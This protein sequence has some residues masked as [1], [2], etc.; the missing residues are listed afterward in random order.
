[1][2]TWI[3][4]IAML[5]SDCDPELWRT[6][7]RICCQKELKTESKLRTLTWGM[8]P[9]NGDP[10]WILPGSISNHFVVFLPQERFSNTLPFGHHV[11]TELVNFGIF[12]FLLLLLTLRIS[13]HF[14]ENSVCVFVCFP[15]S[16]RAGLKMWW[17]RQFSVNTDFIRARNGFLS[18]TSLFLLPSD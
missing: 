1:M 8:L 15:F 13:V 6:W 5:H 4:S 17:D 18:T 12:N 10:T 3:L 16:S 9:S 14:H 7:P 2:N 11:N